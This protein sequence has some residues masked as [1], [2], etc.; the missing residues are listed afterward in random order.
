MDIRTLVRKITRA[1][2]RFA[3]KT[4][5]ALL[6]ALGI[7]GISLAFSDA[8]EAAMHLA[9]QPMGWGSAITISAVIYVAGRHFPELMNRIAYMATVIAVFG[10]IVRNAAR[11]VENAWK[12][13]F[14]A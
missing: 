9:A 3:D 1:L 7:Y 6:C 8:G 10:I 5:A 2:T 14:G 12:K 4:R 11:K 13:F